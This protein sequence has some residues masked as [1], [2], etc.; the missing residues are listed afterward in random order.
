MFKVNSRNTKTKCETYFT[1]CSSVSIVNFEQVNA[2]WVSFSENLQT[3]QMDDPKGNQSRCQKNPIKVG[4]L[5]IMIILR[6]KEIL[7]LNS[8]SLHIPDCYT[9]TIL[10]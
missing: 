8:L 1:H 4:P 6:E 10:I 9:S 2:D 7:M 5:E 3:H